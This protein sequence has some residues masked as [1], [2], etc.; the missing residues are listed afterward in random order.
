MEDRGDIE[1]VFIF[2]LIWSV[3]A[4]LVN[5]SRDRFDELV[6]K[7]AGVSAN[8]PRESLYGH[9]YNTVTHKWEAWVAPPYVQPAPFHFHEVS[10]YASFAP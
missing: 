2:S 10:Y 6:K 5:Q 1:G 7:L 9:R 4:A 8:C 3:G